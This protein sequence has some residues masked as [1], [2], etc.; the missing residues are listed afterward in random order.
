M[1]LICARFPLIS[2][3]FDSGVWVSIF[4]RKI[5]FVILNSGF[6]VLITILL[7]RVIV[8]ILKSRFI[9]IFQ[10]GLKIKGICVRSP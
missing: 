6:D 10:K 4:H 8:F 5:T 9:M 7:I 3:L 1:V 2:I